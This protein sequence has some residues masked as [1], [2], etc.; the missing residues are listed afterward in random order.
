MMEN[1]DCDRYLERVKSENSLYR[2][3]LQVHD[4]P[5][6]FHYWSNRYI[7]PKLEGFGFSTPEEMFHFYVAAQ[8][9]RS[10]NLRKRFVSLGC[11]NGDREISLARA[12]LT[13]GLRDFTIECIDLNQHMLQRAA[14]EARANGLEEV[15]VFECCDLNHWVP[16][17]E[18]DAVLANQSLHHIAA[19]ESVF[20]GVWKSLRPSGVFVISD[21]IGRNGH[22]RWPEALHLVQA[23][24]RRLPP[25]YR[26]NHERLRY[27]ESFEDWD[28]S[29]VGFEGIRSQDIL[30]LLLRSFQFEMF[31]GFGNI[32]DPFVDRSYGPNFDPAYEPDRIFIDEV[33][34]RD[35]MGLMSGE[36]KPTHMLAAVVKE[37]RGSSC[38]FIGTLTPEYCVRSSTA[39]FEAQKANLDQIWDSKSVDLDREVRRMIERLRTLNGRLSEEIAKG[40]ARGLELIAQYHRALSAEDRLHQIRN[41][42]I[43]SILHSARRRLKALFL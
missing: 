11:G 12:L 23:F 9:K 22:L 8:W 18:Y 42:P 25:S 35:E 43:I 38:R 17:E 29:S 31:A 39:S 24:W 6:I 14:S 10:D 13:E 33:H 21:I 19:L 30:P 2:N 4:L 26:F 32:V 20:D 36:L 15:L 7:R 3:C 41:Y 37:N 5:D 28:C 34:E 1:P 16:V 27:Q 40:D